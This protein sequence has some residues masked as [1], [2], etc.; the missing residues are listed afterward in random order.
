MKT[1]SP[2]L[3][4][5]FV[6]IGTILV[7]CP[8]AADAYQRRQFPNGGGIN[9]LWILGALAVFTEQGR[10]F[11]TAVLVL[12]G[13][14]AMVAV[15][16]AHYFEFYVW[17]VAWWLTLISGIFINFQIMRKVIQHWWGDGA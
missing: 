12:F 6:L 13:P 9:I 10:V 7:L 8:E 11:L 15:A 17:S 5:L 3:L 2:I 4:N 1:G 14:G 16:A